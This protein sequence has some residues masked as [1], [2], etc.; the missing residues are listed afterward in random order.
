MTLWRLEWARVWRTRRWI[1]LLGVYVF[2]G[3]VG[4]P[5][6]KYANAIFRR[7]GQ[8]GATITL[9]PATP[10]DG[11]ASFVKNAGQIGL[12]VAIVVAAGALALDAKPEVAAF[13]RTRVRPVRAVFA[14]R[15]VVSLVWVL[16]AFLA[17]TVA[18]WYETVVLIGAVPAGRLAAGTALGALFLAFAIAVVALSASLARSV[19]ATVGISLG[20]LLAM[21][22]MGLVRG[23]GAWMPTQLA[24]ALEGLLS[25]GTLGDYGRAVLVT[26]VGG[27]GALW[28]AAV[29][30]ERREV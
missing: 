8:S 25:G 9:P 22:I 18:A 29:R 11:M 30:L 16:I 17:G 26:V 27:L 21:P 3:L 24:G 1:A 15:Y 28:W 13:F 12:V 4:P 2:F 19:I 6:V 5:S 10:A 20:V 7:F 14:P 23:V